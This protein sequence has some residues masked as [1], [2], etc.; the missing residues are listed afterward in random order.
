MFAVDYGKRQL[1][2]RPW[3]HM[4]SENVAKQFCTFWRAF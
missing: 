3:L 2:I 1:F 4:K